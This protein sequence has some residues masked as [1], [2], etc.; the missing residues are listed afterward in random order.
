MSTQQS[1]TLSINVAVPDIPFIELTIPHL[2]KSCNY[3]FRERMLIVDT[4]PLAS[5]YRKNP[6]IGTH[7]QL[8]DVCKRLKDR[9]VIDDVREVDYSS[10]L[11]QKILKKHLGECAWET[12]DFRGAPVYPYLYAYEIADSDYFLHFDSDMMFHQGNGE[13]WVTEAIRILRENEDVLSVTQLPGPPSKDG[14]LKQRGVPYSLDDRG[15]YAFKEFTSRRFLFDR[16]RFDSVLPLDPVY[17]HDTWKR[18]LLS[19]LA[20]KI[21]MPQWEYLVRRSAMRQWEYLVSLKLQS[22]RFIRADTSSPGAWTLHP[23]ARGPEFIEEL[24]GILQRIERGDFPEEQRGDYELNFKA[25]T[26]RSASRTTN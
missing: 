4:A 21:T 25:W 10:K 18:K 9:N 5:R 3:P 11:R 26:K 24:P 14:E 1:C 2:V 12:H 22:S 8:L 23:L 17:T 16:K 6:G 15:F 20:R 7:E 13:N 19:R